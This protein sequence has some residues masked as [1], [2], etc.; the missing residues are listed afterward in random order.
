MEINYIQVI[1]NWPVAFDGCH[2]FYVIEDDDDQQMMLEY[3]YTLYDITQLP[4]LYSMACPLKFIHNAKLTTT[5]VEQFEN[6]I[7]E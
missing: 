6:A 2:K 7:F 3:G 5:Y 1:S 4:H